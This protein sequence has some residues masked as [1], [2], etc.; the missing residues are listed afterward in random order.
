MMTGS[1][2]S[3]QNS[4]RTKFSTENK[5]IL[6]QETNS[7]S[8]WSSYSDFLALCLLILYNDISKCN[9]LTKQPHT[10]RHL[11]IRSLTKNKNK[12]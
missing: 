9:T 8:S 6:R 4:L 10:H 5:L 12:P 11:H 2:S 3:E 1:K 7:D